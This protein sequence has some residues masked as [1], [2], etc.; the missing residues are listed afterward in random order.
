MVCPGKEIT[1][2]VST[3]VPNYIHEATVEAAIEV[4]SNLLPDDRREIVEGHGVDNPEELLLDLM[5]E[6][7]TVYFTVPNGKT[8]GMAGVSDGN[9]VW[10][11]CTTA[12]QEYPLT[13]VREAKR[14][15]QSR[16][17]PML[18][19]AV[20][21]RNKTHL[22]LLKHL[23]FHFI[24]SYEFGPNNITFIEFARLNGEYQI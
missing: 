21:S 6:P 10:M 1:Q 23:G 16:K 3:N 24:N 17:E 14:W 22:K 11:L 18:W 7:E 20:D 4:A 8:A 12:I 15:V 9:L 2:L 19:N 13:F 5:W